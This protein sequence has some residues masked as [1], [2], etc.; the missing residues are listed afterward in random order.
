MDDRQCN[1]GDRRFNFKVDGFQLEDRKQI[2]HIRKQWHLKRHSKFSR[3]KGSN[4]S[5]S[6]VG[7]REANLHFV[8]VFV[9]DQNLGENMVQIESPFRIVMHFKDDVKVELAGIETNAL[10]IMQVHL[11]LF[12][13]LLHASGVRVKLGAKGQKAN[14]E[15]G[16]FHGRFL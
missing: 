13:G 15:K 12:S 10:D 16:F 14:K 2:A 6:Q 1:A 11:K 7:R 9:R 4:Q 5:A 8:A 3:R